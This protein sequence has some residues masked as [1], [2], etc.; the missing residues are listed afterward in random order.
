[1]RAKGGPNDGPFFDASPMGWLMRLLC[2]PSGI[3][4]LILVV[5][6]LKRSPTSNANGKNGHAD[7]RSGRQ[8]SRVPE[9]HLRRIFDSM[10]LA[11][12]RQRELELSGRIDENSCGY[13]LGEGPKTLG[14][15]QLPCGH[16]H[17]GHCFRRALEMGLMRCADCGDHIPDLD[18]VI[19]RKDSH[20]FTSV[21]M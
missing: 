4:T 21:Q 17:H 2:F 12:Q 5:L 3:I 16:F 6:L 1:M 9:K 20:Q 13:C 14:Y 8:G 10:R 7:C 15:V 11:R 19:V 18:T